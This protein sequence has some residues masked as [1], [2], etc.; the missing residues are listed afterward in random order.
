MRKGEKW[1]SSTTISRNRRGG[2]DIAGNGRGGIDLYYVI[3]CSERVWLNLQLY[4][5]FHRV[6]AA[7]TPPNLHSL[8]LY[9]M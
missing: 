7:A 6:T 9:T 1:S 8:N 4:S 2:I 3:Y 5:T